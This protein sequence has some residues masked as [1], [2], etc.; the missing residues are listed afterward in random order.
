MKIFSICIVTIHRVGLDLFGPAISGVISFF[1]RIVRVKV[2]LFSCACRCPIIQH[3]IRS[4]FLKSHSHFVL[5]YI[6]FPTW[7]PGLSLAPGISLF[8]QANHQYG[9][10]GSWYILIFNTP[11]RIGIVEITIISSKHSDF[12]IRY[13]PKHNIPSAIGPPCRGHL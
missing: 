7:V 1:S 5:R 2:G 6:R 12:Q 13:L 9:K 3:G 4:N 10:I 11:D 8:T